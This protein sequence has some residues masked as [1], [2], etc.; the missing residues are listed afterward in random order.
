MIQ[1]LQKLTNC[2]PDTR[3]GSGEIKIRVYFI[4]YLFYLKLHEF[5]EFS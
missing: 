1:K 5:S 4:T 3:Q 2:M